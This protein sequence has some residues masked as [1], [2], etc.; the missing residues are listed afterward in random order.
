MS[1]W[2]AGAPDPSMMEPFLMTRSYGIASPSYLLY[3]YVI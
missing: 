3:S 1:A 2:N